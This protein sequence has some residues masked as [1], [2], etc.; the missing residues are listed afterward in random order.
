MQRELNIQMVDLKTQY[1]HIKND[2]DNAMQQVINSTQFI[3]GDEVKNFQAELADYLGVKHV[4]TCG[5]GTDALQ[6]AM[7]GLGLKP[8]DEVITPSF[9]YIATTEV[10]GLLGLKP[11]FVDCDPNTFNISPTAI[12]KAITKKTRAIVPVHLFGQS[13]DMAEIMNIASKYNLF[14]I[15]DNAQAIGCTYNGLDHPQKTGTIG[16]V[17][18]TSFFPSK[19]LGCY[20]DGGAMMTNDDELAKQLRMIAN[21]GQSKKYYHDRVG[22]NSRLD[23]IQAAVLRIKLRQ[24]DTYIHNRQKAAAFYDKHFK[25]ESKLKTPERITDSDHVFHQYTLQLDDSIKRDD[26]ISYLKEYGIPAMVYYPVPAHLQKMFSSIDVSKGDLSHTEW[27]TTRV[28]SLP[29]HTEL[30]EKQQLF[31]VSHIKNYLNTNS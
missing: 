9:T 7:M 21:H 10:I 28:I 12:E 16:N 22:C 30:T 26:L 3:N 25:S 6:I 5:N 24:L 14:V 11:V 18:C 8:G 20:G 17:G 31:I 23:N 27:L 4:I 1:E 2:V 13:C 15:E 29:M 19:N